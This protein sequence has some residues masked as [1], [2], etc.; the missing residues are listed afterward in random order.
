MY[1]TTFYSFRGGVGRT[2]SLV[3]IA[4]HLAET[5]RRVLIVDF[6]LEAPGIRTYQS[7]GNPA[8]EWNGLVDYV[9]KYLDTSVVPDLPEFVYQP[10]L[11]IGGPGG[12]WIM[13]SGREDALYSARLSSVDWSDLYSKREGYLLFE[14]LK[15]QWRKYLNPD[16]V[17]IDSRT[18]HTE[19]GGICTRQLADAVVA[20]FVPTEQNLGG[21]KKV[22]ADVKAES[23]KKEIRIHYVM[24]NVPDLDDEYDVVERR[25]ALFREGLGFRELS[26][27]IHHYPSL[28][29][30]EQPIFTIER[31]TSRLA[32]EYV[33]LANAIIRSNLRDRE[34]A[35]SRLR[36]AS[37]S[38]SASELDL[39]RSEYAKDGDVLYELANAHVRAGRVDEALALLNAA[40]KNGCNAGE[41]YV[42]RAGLN[43]RRTDNS[44]VA[45]DLLKALHFMMSADAL[46]RA[47]QLLAE[48]HPEGLRDLAESIAFDSLNLRAK[49]AIAKELA[50]DARTVSL[51]ARLLRPLVA[52]ANEDRDVLL[53]SVKWFPLVLIADG[54]PGEALMI[55]KYTREQAGRPTLPDAFNLAMAS[56]AATREVSKELF[57]EVL[58]AAVVDTNPAFRTSP[59]FSQSLA[60]SHWAVGDLKKAAEY[61]SLSRKQI[62]EYPFSEFSCWRYLKVNSV[63]FNNDLDAMERMFNG[64]ELLPAFMSAR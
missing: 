4:A 57:K 10:S 2:M 7:M 40:E 47:V 33:T 61:L 31:P 25:L 6:D 27:T 37:V 38:L 12:L 63:E 19:V 51:G 21:L 42:I 11:K 5:G 48:I 55:L 56:W 24:S 58:D 39:I 52:K 36:D 26:A 1:V 46:N 34:G 59:N 49:V 23:P 9:K 22:I 8:G 3:N 53:E 30:M 43:Y 17:L 16:Y 45:D 28:E 62:A 35:L 15:A 41:L 60:M 13:P 20:L 14:E 50:M 18:G 44:E 54:L 64:E 29:L 32:R